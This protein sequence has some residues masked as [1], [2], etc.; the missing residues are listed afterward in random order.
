MYTLKYGQ[1]KIELDVPNKADI[2]L[3]EINFIGTLSGVSN[4]PGEFIPVVGKNKLFI[5]NGDPK[6]TQLSDNCILYYTSQCKIKYAKVYEISEL[7]KMNENTKLREKDPNIHIDNVNIKRPVRVVE[8]SSKMNKLD[9]NWNTLDEA[10]DYDYEN[11]VGGKTLSKSSIVV[12]NAKLGENTKYYTKDGEEYN[13]PIHYHSDLRVMTG[14]TH[15]EDSKMLYAS[16]NQKPL[17]PKDLVGKKINY[18]GLLNKQITKGK[19]SKGTFNEVKKYIKKS[20]RTSVRR[21]PR[22]F[23]NNEN[24]SRNNPSDDGSSGGY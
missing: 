9:T 21:S 8:V 19:Y 15:T 12:N 5:V 14:G 3:I 4:M 10:I 16:P 13:G 11:R 17:F 1:G 23:F 24:L 22:N 7:A 18:K 2:Y 20:K 6:H